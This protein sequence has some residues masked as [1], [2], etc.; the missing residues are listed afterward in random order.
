MG[1]IHYNVG[2]WSRCLICITS[3]PPIK[4]HLL[5]PNRFC[6]KRMFEA[7][8]KNKKEEMKECILQT[9]INAGI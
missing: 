7:K 6:R 1:N 8:E 5:I 4:F 9:K 3:Y 2:A